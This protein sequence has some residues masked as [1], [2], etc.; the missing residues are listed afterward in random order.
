MATVQLKGYVHHSRTYDGKDEFTFFSFDASSSSVDGYT[1]IAPAEF[2]WE[3]PA[4][5][6]PTASQIAALQKQRDKA[7][8]DFADKVRGID[9]QLSKL[10]AIEHT[11]AA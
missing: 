6:S 7:A 5:F 4:D 11:E 3:L 9:F 2:T 1:M 8:K 10:Q